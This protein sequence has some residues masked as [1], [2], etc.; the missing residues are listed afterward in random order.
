MEGGTR[1]RV[2]VAGQWVDTAKKIG[3]LK[4]VCFQLAG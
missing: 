1:M 4:L 3:V 2:Y